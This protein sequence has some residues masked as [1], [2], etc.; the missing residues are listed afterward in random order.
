MDRLLRV[1]GIGVTVALVVYAATLLLTDAD[2]V[3]DDAIADAQ[4]GEDQQEQAERA[5]ERVRM[6]GRG[7]AMS[8]DGAPVS[9]EAVSSEAA[10]GDAYVQYGSGQVD[11]RSARDGFEYAMGRVDEVV[12]SRRRLSMDD[13]DALYREANDAFSALS[14]VLDAADEAQLTELEAA[15]KRLKQGLR[16]VRVRGRKFAR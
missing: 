5:R 14:I 3:V 10:P 9:A 16:K 4:L 15:H 11:Q 8:P 12:K 13:W 7:L 2:E 6:L 1:L